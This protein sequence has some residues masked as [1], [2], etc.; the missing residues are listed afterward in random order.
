MLKDR[1]WKDPESEKGVW[2]RIYPQKGGVPVISKTRKYWVKLLFLGSEV[3]VEIDD[4]MP[5]KKSDG[6]L[7]VPHSA[8]IRD[9]W[10]TLLCK[11]YLKLS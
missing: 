6:K 3:L 5:C 2:S 10:S 4:S 7:L 9:L 11:A 1:N 8:Y